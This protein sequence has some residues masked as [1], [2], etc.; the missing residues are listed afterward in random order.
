M[1]I[2][3][4]RYRIIKKDINL[5]WLTM[6][7]GFSHNNSYFL[8][9]GNYF[10]KYFNILMPNLMGHGERYLDNGPFGFEEYSEDIKG[11]IDEL[12][13]SKTIFWGTH[14]GAAVG[15]ILS[16]KFPLLINSLILEGAPV[17]GYYMPNV[18]RFFN[19]AKDVF[20][21]RGLEAALSHWINRSAWF[22][23]INNKPIKC[24]KGKHD[25]MILSFKGAHFST[26]TRSKEVFN[27][28]NNFKD[29]ATPTLCYNGEYD[30]KEFKDAAK[31]LKR[32]NPD[33]QIEVIN[34]SGGFPLWEKPK[35][36]LNLVSNYLNKL[37][38][39]KDKEL[40]D[41]HS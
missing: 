36:V 3:K 23:N 17:P 29:I 15:L 10:S 12:D 2:E 40:K 13:I 7:H 28:L 6:V 39:L 32:I 34:N 21:K 22:E 11:I 35:D 8:E 37:G 25:T 30:L 16:C 26:D 18:A 5:P 41:V 20:K 19:N 4:I 9:Q 24:R 1:V 14:T 38:L 27:V 31:E 33:V